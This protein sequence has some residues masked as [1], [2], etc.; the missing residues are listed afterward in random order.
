MSTSYFALCSGLGRSLR[1]GEKPSQSSPSPVDRRLSCTPLAAVGSIGVF[2]R[3]LQ[4]SSDRDHSGMGVV[5][6]VPSRGG[7]FYI[8]LHQS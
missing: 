2:S 5:D 3:G 6:G 7:L 4:V 1:W 8:F